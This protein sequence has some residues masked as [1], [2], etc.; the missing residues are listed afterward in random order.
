MG[1]G[2]LVT[3]TNTDLFSLVFKLEGSIFVNVAN[4]VV[5]SLI[6]SLAACILNEFLDWFEPTASSGVVPIDRL[7]YT[8]I[9]TSVAFL[10]VFRS[11]ISYNRFW[12][13]RGHLG[14]IMA[15]ARDLSR[16]VA[17]SVRFDDGPEDVPR[18]YTD[19]ERLQTQQQRV[20]DGG[21][22][23]EASGVREHMLTMHGFR[24][25]QMTRQLLIVW[26]LIVQHLRDETDAASLR[27]V[28]FSFAER[29]TERAK[30]LLTP[31]VVA[32]LERKQ[33]RPLVA[34]AMLSWYLEQ[35]YKNKTITYMEYLSMNAN[36]SGLING[37]N[38]VDKVHTVP[39]PFPY[40]Q[41][42]ILLLSLYC[43][44][45]P[46]M[47]VTYFGWGTFVPAAVVTIAFFGINEVAI[48][49]EDPF[50]LDENDL[51]LDQM[52]D[53]LKDDCEM[54]MEV[55]LVPTANMEAYWL[56]I[57]QSGDMYAHKYQQQLDRAAVEA[58]KG[59]GG[60][61]GAQGGPG[62]SMARLT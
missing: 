4:K 8:I 31:H 11:V 47:L 59:G 28:Y 32:L 34:I 12:E 9:G 5:V 56:E 10:L 58:G 3:Y 60:G 40:A 24:R 42:T 2:G 62:F 61:G 13:G 54:N 53:A 46:F 38:G 35:E 27:K 43:F 37:F 25:L 20:V 44:S 15:H 55:A 19:E 48:E 26:R 41:M 14:V 16:Q 22:Y 29:G 57:A 49:I 30:T 7:A 33:R 52:G 50:G 36:L 51:P 23:V 1:K 45:A 6:I 18:D 17:F 21:P 39:I